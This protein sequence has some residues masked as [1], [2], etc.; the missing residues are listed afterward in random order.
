[1]SEQPFMTI[2]VTLE[3]RLYRGRL[4]PDITDPYNYSVAIRDQ[5]SQI[6]KW[7][8]TLREG[9]YINLIDVKQIDP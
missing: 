7:N 9:E 1:M 6:L 4:L 8:D 3:M 2:T 5:F